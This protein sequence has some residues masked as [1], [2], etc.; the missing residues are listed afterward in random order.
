LI[1]FTGLAHQQLFDLRMQIENKEDITKI[2]N[3]LIDERL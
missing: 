1:Q 2:E 3:E